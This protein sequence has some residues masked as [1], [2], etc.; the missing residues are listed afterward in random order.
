MSQWRGWPASLATAGMTVLV[1][2][3]E[4]P[5]EDQALIL[6]RFD[7]L[8][9]DFKD[10]KISKDQLLAVGVK[11][12]ESPVIQA[13]GVFAVEKNYFEDSGLSA[14]EKADAS[15]QLDRL[16][17]GVYEE[18][19]SLEEMQDAM[20]E[21]VVRS[22]GNDNVTFREPE[23]VDDDDLR[24]LISKVK[25]EADEAEIPNEPFEIDIA[26][27]FIKAID[28]ALGVA[29]ADPPQLSSET[30]EDEPTGGE[31]GEGGGG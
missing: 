27:E 11:L 14:E 10:K 12:I 28:E 2:K 4:L 23:T 15:L 29:T 9:K 26:A 25:A 7:D 31:G 1:E 16:A 5:D 17:R 19:I 21:I 18:K 20:D 30:G 6:A 8:A 24:R 3:L 22:I 13:V